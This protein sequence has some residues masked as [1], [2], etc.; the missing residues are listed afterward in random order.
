MPCE[1][2]TDEVSNFTSHVLAKLYRLLYIHAI[3]TNPYHPQM[4]GMVER[5]NKKLKEML[6]KTIDEEGKDW[7][8]PR[9]VYMPL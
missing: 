9:D 5:F 3:H 2:F 1:I 8:K 6:R 7:D 4:D